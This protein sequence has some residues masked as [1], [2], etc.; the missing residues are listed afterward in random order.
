MDKEELLEKIAEAVSKEIEFE[1][2]YLFGSHARGDYRENSDLDIAVVSKNFENM[3]KKERYEKII[4]SIREVTGET[5]VDLICYT[6]EEFD[7]G[8]NSFLPSIIAEEGIS[9]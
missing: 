1:K 7:R 5:P 6:P 9:V 3:K 2:V 4:E 8:K